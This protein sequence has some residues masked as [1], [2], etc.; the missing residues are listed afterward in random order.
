MK[1]GDTFAVEEMW[2]V[3]GDFLFAEAFEDFRGIGDGDVVEGRQIAAEPGPR[4]L[5][6]GTSGLY[7]HGR[8]TVP[9]V[10]GDVDEE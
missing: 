9:N 6:R 4:P 8:R 10:A 7:L 5:A 2:G 1:E 3:G